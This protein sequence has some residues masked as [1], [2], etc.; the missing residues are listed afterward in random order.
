MA[1]QL[2]IRNGAKLLGSL[3]SGTGDNILT[4]DASTKDVGSIPTIDTSTYLTNSLSSG[5]LLV[6]NSSNVATPRQ[7]TGQVTFSNTGVASIA[8]DTITNANVNTG[9]AITYSKLSLTNSI[10][11]ND[12]AT[13]ANI[14]R[15]KLAA[16]TANRLLVNNGSG[17]FS[18]AAAINPNVVVITDS[19]GIPTHSSVSNVTLGYLDVSS[20]VQTQLNNRL[21]FSSAITPSSGD[22]VIYSGGVWTNLGIG[23]NGQV[24]TLSG[25]LPSWQNG[26]ANGIPSGGTAGQ[27]LNKVDGTNY[28]VQWSTLTL[29]KVTDV[30]AS[31]SDVNLLTGLQSAGL[32]QAE[33][34]YVNGV[35]SSIQTQLNNKLSNSLAQNAIFIGNA[36]NIPTQLA[37]GTEGYVLTITSGTPQWAAPSGG[38]GGSGGHTI[39][40][41]STPLTQRTN[42]NFTG[43]LQAVDDSGND[44][45]VVSLITNSITNS[46]FRQSA[47]LSVVGNAS[48]STA[49][50]A[51][52]SAG[53]NYQILRRNGTSIGF[54]SI[55]LS[56]ADAVGS[57]VLAVVNGGTGLSSLGTSLQSIRVNSGATALEFYTPSTTLT[58]EATGTGGS[59]ISV[60]LTNSAVIGKVLTGYSS[61]AGTV[62]ATDTIL[63]AIQKLDGNNG[64]N[65]KL[66]G[67]STLTGAATITSNA[68]SQHIFN[69]TW[70]ATANNQYHMSFSPTVTGR[71]AASGDVVGALIINPSI[72]CGSGSNTSVLTGLLIQPTFN[73]NSAS[74]VI[75]SYIRCFDGTNVKFQVTDTNVSMAGSTTLNI[76]TGVAGPQL[77]AASASLQL[78]A[79][80]ASGN[81][82]MQIAGN[83]W[84][85]IQASNSIGATVFQVPTTVTS[86]A[87]QQ[88]SRNFN[89][90]VNEWT[91]SAAQVNY[92]TAR[93]TQST[94]TNQLS[95]WDLAF[96]TTGSAPSLT[97]LHL[98]IRN[99][100]GNVYI[101]A[102]TNTA[103]DPTAKLHLG[104]GTATASTAP[105]KFTAGT[106]LTTPE[107]G[108]VE[109]DGT[110]YF[111]TS[112]STRYTLAKTL[113]ATATLDFPSTAA[114]SSSDL[115]ITVTGATS[116][117]VVSLGVPSGSV[118]SN[119]TFFAF[120]SSSDTVTVRLLNMDTVSSA[121]PTSGTFRATV[122]KY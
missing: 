38:G 49:N 78:N 112:S 117:D 111:V 1:G 14:T 94:A 4:L 93:A 79:T 63:Q 13:N 7:I 64:L 96:G 90:S 23:S 17:V 51:D 98:R 36:S 41:S 77:S 73:D 81:V 22:I 87:T 43:A 76:T 11:N 74:G 71:T 108:A 45:S 62:A 121:D 105:L 72:T 89:W 30:T 92:W 91:G 120:V 33:L 114:S 118:P 88:S 9:A 25:G 66:T 82:L 119:C 104:A 101:G 42:L 12:I 75:H 60:T 69:G 5:Y 6:G 103:V 44:A 67:T 35:T 70:T 59:S 57:S 48:N 84:F 47:A 8:A 28:N 102:G 40:N 46:L 122:L 21:A 56:Q 32:T 15:T 3:P 115:T 97:N 107:A 100:N 113:T 99:T 68:N 116:G 106:N 65:W 16:G 2:V 109:F 10:V 110:N 27:Y 52:I 19:N 50:V 34:G 54:G 24:L 53:T 61:G 29:D 26:T 31:A 37:A 58:G 95:Y 39:Q 20:S 18:E 83:S 80:S 86:T 55:D 85:G